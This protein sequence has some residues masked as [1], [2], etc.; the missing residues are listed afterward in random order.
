MTPVSACEDLGCQASDTSDTCDI[1]SFTDCPDSEVGQCQDG[2]NNDDW[3]DDQ[4]DCADPDC[5]DD[6]ACAANPAAAPAAS[7]LGLAALL[8]TLAGIGALRLL[9]RKSSSG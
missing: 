1:V 8:V 4:T 5:Q 2:V 3:V 7:T 9:P 6:P